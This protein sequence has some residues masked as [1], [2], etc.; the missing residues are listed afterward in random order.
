MTLDSW[1]IHFGELEELIPVVVLA[2]GKSTRYS[3]PKVLEKINNK[4]FLE[5]ILEA[6]QEITDDII[7]AVSR[8]TPEQATNIAQKYGVNIVHDNESLLCEGPPRALI[9]VHSEVN[10]ELYL[11]LGVDYP[12]IR[13]R[14][15]KDMLNKYE[16]LGCSALA[17]ILYKGFIVSTVG[18]ISS[19]PLEALQIIC[20]I[21]KFKTRVT[22]IYRLSNKSCYVS[23]KYF[24]DDPEEFRSI[25]RPDDL[26]GVLSRE[27]V[28]SLADN[29]VYIIY[30]SYY[31]NVV[32]SIINND[33][34]RILINLRKE[35]KI[36]KKINLKLLEIHVSKDIKFFEKLGFQGS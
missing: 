1:N 33:K 15:L 19:E 4:T 3:K 24:T 20:S 16:E 6:A 26:R 14:T 5:R 9:S 18:I 28:S 36:Y 23:W 30:P 13:G 12:F 35:L 17:P 10:R 25:N 29:E 27:E 21:K 11:V 34:K 32:V 2:G 22:D 31:R 7:V 8:H